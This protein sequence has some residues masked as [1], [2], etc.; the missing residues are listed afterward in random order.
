MYVFVVTNSPGELIGWVRPVTKKLKEKVKEVIITVV[1][2][3][4]QYASGMEE[5]VAGKIAGVDY[6][7][8]PSQYLKYLFLGRKPS[9]FHQGRKGVIVFLGGDPFH[10]VILA[11][12]LKLPAV[13]YI[14]RLRWKRYFKK[15]MVLDD[16]MREKF[17]AQGAKEEKVVPVG[18]LTKDGINLRMSAKETL[19]YWGLDSE[20]FIISF[21]PGSRSQEVRYM[22]PF[23]LRVAE[24]I[25]EEFSSSQFLLILS[26][27][28]PREELIAGNENELGK[29]F[30]K[31][32]A[33]LQRENSQW[34]LVTESGLKVLLAEE[35]RYEA[36]NISHLIVTIPGTNTLESTYLGTPMVVTIPLNK[37]EAIP[38]DG[39]AGLVGRLPFFGSFIKKKVVRGYSRRIKFTA[40]PN[41]R[42]ERQIVPEIMGVIEP[43]NVAKEVTEL[44]RNPERLTKMK[45]ELR[46]IDATE[47][48]AD[49][50]ANIILEVGSHMCTEG[51]SSKKPYRSHL[52]ESSS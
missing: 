38:L 21:L 18:D 26:P 51:H 47:G 15:F 10:A 35:N 14:Q 44:L 27:F 49:K 4:C 30:S 2:P 13:A 42:A 5:K 23:F 46:N 32:R 8:G 6:V 3:P 43:A 16:V 12:R 37:P 19:R 28:V 33:R 41:I 50:V 20:H 22:A 39:L 7:V 29:A 24:L 45:E 1:I 9:S 31:V 25:K 48:A 17:I 36:M 40:I 52:N 11:R 34:K